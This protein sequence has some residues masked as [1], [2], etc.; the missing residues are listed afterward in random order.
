M[1]TKIQM[2]DKL[3]QHRNTTTAFPVRH[4]EVH[5]TGSLAPHASNTATDNNTN[6]VMLD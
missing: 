1:R 3:K 6:K 4:G 5:F 2:K